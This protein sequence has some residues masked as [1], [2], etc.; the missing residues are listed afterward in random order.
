MISVNNNYIHNHSTTAI[1]LLST[2]NLYFCYLYHSNM[3]ET[4]ENNYDFLEYPLLF[5]DRL[6]GAG[7]RTTAAAALYWPLRKFRP[8]NGEMETQEPCGNYMLNEIAGIRKSLRLYIGMEYFQFARDRAR[9]YGLLNP[10]TNSH[11]ILT[12]DLKSAISSLAS[13]PVN[14]RLV[15]DIFYE[16]HHKRDWVSATIDKWLFENKM[17]LAPATRTV[18]N[19]L[20]EDTRGGFTAI[21]R[22]A[23]C[24]AIAVYKNALYNTQQWNIALSEPST[25]A[26]KIEDR[27]TYFKIFI[28][29]ETFYYVVTPPSPASQV[30]AGL[31]STIIKNRCDIDANI[32]IDYDAIAHTINVDCKKLKKAIRNNSYYRE[33]V[34]NYVGDYNEEDLN[35]EYIDKQNIGDG[36]ATE[37]GMVIDE[38][39]QNMDRSS[40]IE[41]VSDVIGEMPPA[42]L[43]TTGNNN[44]YNVTTY[45][46]TTTITSKNNNSS[47]Y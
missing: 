27:K 12:S 15:Y 21:A 35:D 30:S 44:N 14:W 9:D 10:N 22:F 45:Y 25:P 1:I 3:A 17:R 37:L 41:I 39:I 28:D 34:D 40:I 43:S 29:K 6:T 26:K 32:D 4:D 46:I 42:S 5:F 8:R 11:V 24:Q 33:T 23:K 47:T 36:N 2:I 38:N 7:P 19:K 18:G 31:E 20:Y 13:T 16:F